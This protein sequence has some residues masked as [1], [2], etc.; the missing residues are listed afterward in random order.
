MAHY[1]IFSEW[2]SFTTILTFID[3]LFGIWD[4]YLKTFTWNHIF[5][6]MD[7]CKTRYM[8]TI[9]GIGDLDPARWP[10][11]HWRSVKVIIF[12]G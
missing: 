11:S 8:G 7:H 6:C 1:V 4:Y 2:C 3:V 5:F 12:C 10:N 9:T